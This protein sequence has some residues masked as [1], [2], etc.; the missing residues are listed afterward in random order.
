MSRLLSASASASCLALLFLATSAAHAGWSSD[1]AVNLSVADAAGDQVQPKVAPTT[2]G[3]AYISWFDAIANGFDVRVQKLDA[4]GD[5]LLAHNGILVADRGFSS[6]QD[7]GLDVD[8]FGNALLAFRDDGPGGVQITA[9]KVAPDGATLWGPTGV[10]LTSTT[11]FVAAPEIAGT[12][13]GGVVVAWTQES[14]IRLQKLDGL[15]SPVWG[16][17]VTITPGAGSYS[18]SDLHDSGA[19]DVIVSFTHMTGLFPSPRHLLTQKLDANGTLLWGTGHVT[20]FDGGSLQFGNFPSFVPDGSGGAV[21]S[22]YDAASTQLQCYAQRV[23]ANGTEA[24]P[25]NG[26]AASLNAMRVRVSPSVS[27]NSSTSE[28]FLFWEEENQSQSQAGVYGQK[29]DAGGSRQW[30]DEGSVVVP[31][32]VD[33]MTMV[34]CLTAGLGAFVFW[35]RSPSF[36]QDRLY[37][38]RLDGDGVID[39]APF[40]VASTPSQKSRLDVGRS[41]SG[42]AILAWSDARADA[43][44]ILAQNVN[45]DGT[46]GLPP[47]GIG[48]ADNAGVS[49]P[50]L[51][52]PW[53]NPTTG[54]V[55]LDYHAGATPG[56]PK[57][58]IYD[59]R[60]RLVRRLAARAGTPDGRSHWNGLDEHGAR[61]PDGVYFIR[62]E[63]PTVTLTER[64]TVIR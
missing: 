43:G 45:P 47:T 56:N 34:R 3:G 6:T 20:V 28:T 58:E 8:A 39:I 17:G 7:Y 31:V 30:T 15:G 13:D 55:R 42:F 23:L 60:G 59:V 36:G 27:F 51:G 29:F 52:V 53:P 14:T 41:T 54:P 63:T 32:G 49:R 26:A 21:F 2:D 12:G 57:L 22:W 24:F 50:R 64:I 10:Q 46:L 33:E 5:E 61:V 1:P 37:G 4:A 40:D 25:H 62:L 19:G 11:D 44:D 38:A 18:V 9:S 35:S 16:A 48:A